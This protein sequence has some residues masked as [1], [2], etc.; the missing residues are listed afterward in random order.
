MHT[1]LTH[2]E[3]VANRLFLTF[4]DMQDA[5]RYLDAYAELEQ[6]QRERS[7]SFFSDHCEAILSASIVAYCRPF[8]NSR[9]KGNAASKLDAVSIDAVCQQLE[10]HKL[11]ETKRDTF[12]AHADWDARPTAF[13][14]IDG[15]VVLRKSPM[16]SVHKG[17][18]IEDFRELVKNV[19]Y[20]CRD[21]AF[22]LDFAHDTGQADVG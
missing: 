9:S 10:L 6:M 15:D 13:V 21:K 11:L 4:K 7:D 3:K 20:E 12:I 14:R 18:N 17:L 8:K 19:G 16:P 2:H 5:M 1:T 22:K